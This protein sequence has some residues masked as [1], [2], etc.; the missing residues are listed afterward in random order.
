MFLPVTVTFGAS[1]AAG[2]AGRALL[3]D[4]WRQQ[5]HGSFMNNNI[6]Q[7]GQEDSARVEGALE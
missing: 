5:D 1:P 4:L 3:E 6:S 7:S 2:A